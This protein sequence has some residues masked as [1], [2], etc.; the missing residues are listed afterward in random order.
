MKKLLPVCLLLQ[1]LFL[2]SF[3]SCTKKAGNQAANQYPQRIV[4]LSPSAG[5]ILFAVGAEDQIAAVSEFT[6]YPPEA[7]SKPV[8]GGFDGKTLSMESILGF[9]PDFLYLTDGMHNFLIE[10]LDAY[11]IKYYLSKG[12]SIKAVMQEIQDIGMLT[13]H[14]EKAVDIVQDMTKKIDGVKNASSSST[15]TLSRPLYYEVWN[16]PFM[17]A[18]ARSFIN[19][20]ISTSGTANIFGDVDEAYP[21]VSEET[22][23]A[24]QPEYILIPASCGITVEA[25]KTR[26]GWSDIPAVKNNKVFLIDDN[27]YTRPG[28]RVADVVVELNAL[29]K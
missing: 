21:I 28:P 6:D 20:I 19:D 5:E 4:A 1:G 24:R 3:V 13:G 22:I 26:N 10:Q 14:A 12:D 23:I 18:G 16:A 2:L 29:L 25:V 15:S 8:V 11:G 9:K 7:A 17:T 27:I